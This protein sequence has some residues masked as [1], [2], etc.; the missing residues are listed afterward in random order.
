MK[1]SWG[2]RAG[3]LYLCLLI[4]MPLFDFPGLR[5]FLYFPLSFFQGWGFP[6]GGGFFPFE[7]F[8]FIGRFAE[9]LGRKGGRPLGLGAGTLASRNR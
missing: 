9:G 2:F 8:F 7:D 1:M 5:G 3:A 4:H 6:L